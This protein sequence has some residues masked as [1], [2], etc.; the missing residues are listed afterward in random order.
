MILVYIAM[1][2]PL[3]RYLIAARSAPSHWR[4]SS[5]TLVVKRNL[6]SHSEVTY[7]EQWERSACWLS[8]APRWTQYRDTAPYGDVWRVLFPAPGPRYSPLQQFIQMQAYKFRVCINVAYGALL[9]TLRS[10][11]G[12]TLPWYDLANC[13]Y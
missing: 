13:T 11:P 6:G 10:L 8:V 5:L 9:C 7:S 1:E 3:M 4:K 2:S 12:E